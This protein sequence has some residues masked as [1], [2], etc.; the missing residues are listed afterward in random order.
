MTFTQLLLIVLQ[1]P[2]K[3]CRVPLIYPPSPNFI[4]CRKIADNRDARKRDYTVT[5]QGRTNESEIKNFKMIIKKVLAQLIRLLK[6]ILT[7]KRN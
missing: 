4:H 1:L 6:M 7:S 3:Y 5:R 2:W